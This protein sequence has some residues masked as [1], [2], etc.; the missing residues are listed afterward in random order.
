MPV[1]LLSLR[2][3]ADQILSDIESKTNQDTPAVDVAYN[4]AV[5]NGLAAM[6]LQDQYHNIDQRK[7]CFPQTASEEIGLP[8]WA[9]LVNRPRGTGTQADLQAQATGTNGETI[10]TGSTGPRWKADSGIKYGTKTG[11]TI[12]GGVASIAVIADQAG[13]EGTLQVSDKITL[14]TTIPGIDTTAT[15][16]AI[17]VAGA[18]QETVESWRAAIV[19]LA[20]F[21]PLSGTAAWFYTEALKISGITRAYPYSDQNFPGRI[22]I[23]AV[24]DSQTDGQPTAPQLAEIEAITSTA[25]KNIM[26]AYNLLPNASKR[27][28][29]FASPIDIYDVVITEGVP[30]MSA[31]LK[32]AV[33]ASINNYFLT[34]NPY[35][36]GLSL[37]DQG[38]V[39]EVAITTVAQN[40]IDAEVGETGRFTDIGLTKQGSA[41]ADI[42]ILDPGNRAKAN[43]SYT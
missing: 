36:N 19:Q 43:I 11:A 29:A 17:N 13:T 27:L 20:A 5:A 16:T 40:T 28:E 24:D 38:A 2:E 25:Q 23:Y 33:E 14:T 7:E 31:S 9:G 41:P 32:Q 21:P 4:R 6:S 1:P 10:G 15:I 37:E 12:S 30:A 35:I 42:Y 26:W 8:L 18:P 39:E 3:K 22:L 34:R